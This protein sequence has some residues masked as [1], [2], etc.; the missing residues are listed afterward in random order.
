MTHPT[1]NQQEGLP[2]GSICPHCGEWI[3]TGIVSSVNHFKKSERCMVSTINDGLKTTD[4]P[5][6][7]GKELGKAFEKFM[8]QKFG[9]KEAK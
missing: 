9:K 5:M 8:N 7:G 2:M 4:P 3:D 1:D 6:M